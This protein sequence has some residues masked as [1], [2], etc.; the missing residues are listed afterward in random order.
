[1]SFRDDLLRTG[2]RQLL[3]TCGGVTISTTLVTLVPEPAT[4]MIR[5]VY[6]YF[7]RGAKAS[8][9]ASAN[10]GVGGVATPTV[11]LRF[12]IVSVFLNF[13]VSSRCE[14]NIF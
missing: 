10:V 9:S 2:Q 6:T 7:I 13:E 3:W 4:M 14:K 1:M 8:E 11:T 12:N 5:K